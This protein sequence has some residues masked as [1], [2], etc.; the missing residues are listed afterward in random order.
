MAANIFTGAID[1]FFDKNGNWSLGVAPTQTDGNITMLDATSPNCVVRNFQ[2]CM[3]FTCTGF[4]GSLTINSGFFLKCF[5]T[6]LTLS[7]T[8][9]ILGSGTLEP[10]NTM[11]IT[12]NGTNVPYVNFAYS[13]FFTFTFADAFNN[14]TSF[15]SVVG[16]AIFNGADLYLGGDVKIA[17]STGGGT[18]TFRYTGSSGTW[19]CLAS[20]SLKNNFTIEA[21]ASLTLSGNVYYGAGTLTVDPSATVVT[22]GSNLFIIA[23][24]TLDVGAVNWNNFICNAITATI[25]LTSNLAVTNLT[26]SQSVNINGAFSVNISGNLTINNITDGTST[27][28]LIGTG[29]WSGTGSLKNTMNFNTSGTITVSGVVTYFAGTLTYVTGTIVTTG[30]RLA[31]GGNTTTTLNTNG[32]SWATFSIEGSSTAN[33]TSVLNTANFEHRGAANSTINGANLEVSNNI[34]ST[35]AALRFV[36]GTSLLLYTGTSGV[37]SSTTSGDIRL[38]LTVQAGATLTISGSVYYGTGTLTVDPAATVTTTGSTLFLVTSCTL[39]TSTSNLEIV[40]ISSAITVT[41]NSI[42][43][44][45]TLNISNTSVTFAGSFGYEVNNLVL[46]TPT[47]NRT[48]TFV[49]GVEY[50]VNTSIA[51]NGT[52]TFKYTF[53]SNHATLKALFTLA[54][55]ATQYMKGTN[56]TRIDSSNGQT[57]NT[58]I[59]SYPLTNTINW[60]LSE[61]SWWLVLRS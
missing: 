52:G 6:V 41:L 25:T 56:A 34:T 49:N 2:S 38:S 55:G 45:N 13:N 21:G 59:N 23:S 31:I 22:T 3:N 37:W 43:F 7:G 40:T 44:I 20:Q 4:T 8:M 26:A 16:S 39:N 60:Q 19:T 5:G 10:A 32:I 51:S 36:S 50:K 46:S 33:L 47:A 61:G 57:I 35:V 29:T 9:T 58:S 18:S 27:F 17:S 54:Y 15:R 28:N 14:S 1:S 12:T 48:I 11:T 53:I 42:A 24:C 30:S